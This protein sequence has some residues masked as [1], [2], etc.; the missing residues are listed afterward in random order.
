MSAGAFDPEQTGAWLRAVVRPDTVFEIR[1]DTEHKGIVAGYFDNVDAAI[2]WLRRWDGRANIYVTLNPVHPDLLLR[3]HKNQ[4]HEFRGKDDLTKDGDITGRHN[5]LI[6]IDAIRKKGI[7]ATDSEL[8]DAQAVCDEVL[9]ELKKAGFSDESLFIG[10][11]GNGWHIVIR[12]DLPNDETTRDL[13]KQFLAAIG[14]KFGKGR[15]I[16]DPGVYNASRIDKVYGTV[17]CKGV[18]APDHGRPHRRAAL[19]RVPSEASF[20]P[21]ELFERAIAAWDTRPT[22]ERVTAERQEAAFDAVLAEFKRRDRYGKERARGVHDVTCP[23]ACDHGEDPRG[24]SETVLFEPSE[25]N[26]WQG[27]FDCRHAHS[28]RTPPEGGYKLHHV[29]Q[30]FGLSAPRGSN[31]PPYAVIDGRICREKYETKLD[32]STGKPVTEVT[33]Q[34][35]C[36]F[37]AAFTG[38]V[39]FDDGKE[40]HREYTISGALETGEA[41][42]SASVRAEDFDSMS[43]VGKSWGMRPFVYAGGATRDHL[44]AAIHSLSPG[45]VSRR[46]FAHTGWRVINEK[47]VYLFHGGAIGLDGIEV[48][49]RVPELSRI[50]LPTVPDDVVGAVRTSLNLLNVAPLRV[51]LPLL[52]ATYRA[53]LCHVLGCPVTVWLDGKTGSFKSTMQAVF[54]CHYGEF[55]YDQLL[56]QWSSSANVLERRMFV[57]KDMSFNIDD[58]VPSREQKDAE[59]KVARIIRAQG[60]LAG[61]SRMG[62]D[63]S[64]RGSFPPRG[65][66][67][68]SAEQPPTGEGVLSRTALLKVEPGT[69]HLV[70]LTRAQ[71]AAGRLP[72]AMTG[73]VQWLAPQM[74]TLPKIMAAQ[75]EQM[76]GSLS[77]EG[78]H[79]RVPST[80]AHLELGFCYFLEFAESVHAITAAERRQRADRSH[81]VF[82]ELAEGQNRLVSN[83]RP[84]LRFL[85]VIDELLVQVKVRLDHKDSPSDSAYR[86]GSPEERAEMI[87][88]RDEEHWYLLPDAAHKAVAQFCQQQGAPLYAHPERLREDLKLGGFTDCDTGRTT[89][90]VKVGGRAQRLVKVRIGQAQEAFGG[91]ADGSDEG[92]S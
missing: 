66:T 44:R 29:R 25:K 20:A 70:E 2:K 17:A 61:R 67:I 48:D 58:S 23:W 33:S 16:I 1:I 30:M 54:L 80:M 34:P 85:R 4:L 36:N 75:H 51:T 27:A 83:E 14:A 64:D 79:R 43:W 81:E 57:L 38:D 39:A 24:D 42:D 35:L 56:A 49:L 10:M 59:A 52:A 84:E 82:C 92:K 7:S 40:V 22:A 18:D 86:I 74:P 19:I 13:L 37:T 5:V 3:F 87:G 8:A 21:R 72:H 46:V 65:L 12:V 11:S 45:V 53:P 50:V 73:Y 63:T 77:Q 90:T 76:R 26:Q 89:K 28:K 9:A 88:W 91:G 69:V 71:A 55:A 32:K 68:S 60:N 41:L 62:S 15:A 31:Q 6:D 78:W 47:Y